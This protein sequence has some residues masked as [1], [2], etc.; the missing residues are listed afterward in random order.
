MQQLQ[1][2]A[3]A[4][5]WEGRLVPDVEV[6]GT[7]FTAV[8]RIRQDVH[9]WR[10]HHGWG[11]ELNPAWFKAWSEPER[12]DQLPV[13]AVDL[14]GILV[15]VSKPSRAL[16]ACGM[17]LTLAPCAVVLPG[18]QRYDALS[19]LELDYYGAGAVTTGPGGSGE[20]VITPENRA[21]EF[22]SSMFG[23]WL[24]EV[25]YSRLLDHPQLTE[26]A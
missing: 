12:H 17:L 8:A 6:L 26:N 5:G 2:A 1:H 18:Q 13:A 24:L 25:L 9:Q 15:P 22:G 19:M 3:R 10:R 11:P 20:L 21:A 23:R 14:I 7:R 16:R 4:L